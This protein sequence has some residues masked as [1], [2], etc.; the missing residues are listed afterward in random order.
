MGTLLL[1]HPRQAAIYSPSR[2][3][4]QA[5]AA[6]EKCRHTRQH[7]LSDQASS[8]LHEDVDCPQD[9]QGNEN[10]ALGDLAAQ[11]E[12]K[13]RAAGGRHLDESPAAAVWAAVAA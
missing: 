8:A 9:D 3:R 6:D 13:G 4:P 2:G 5:A 1:A 12:G 7:R 10:D 11:A